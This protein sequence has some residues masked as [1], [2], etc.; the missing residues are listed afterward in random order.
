[1]MQLILRLSTMFELDKDLKTTWLAVISYKW[2]ALL[3][4]YLLCGL[5]FHDWSKK[6][7]NKKLT[8]LFKEI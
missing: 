3:G 8:M 4:L 2:R 5:G 6:N 1:M 7:N